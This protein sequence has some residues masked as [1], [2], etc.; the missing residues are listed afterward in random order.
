VRVSTENGQLV[1]SATTLSTAKVGYQ[2]KINV[3]VQGDEATIKVKAS[4]V[5]VKKIK[6]TMVV[7]EIIKVKDDGTI[8]YKKIAKT[9]I[10]KGKGTVSLAK[11][12]KGKHKLVFFFTGTGK[13]GSNDESVKVKIKR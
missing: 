1:G 4:P 5:K 13:V 3:K 2:P 11:L 12:K 7:K 10:K 6:G 9:K 8:K